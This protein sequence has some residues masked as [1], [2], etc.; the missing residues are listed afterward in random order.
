MNSV[1]SLKCPK[2]WWDAVDRLPVKD[3]I[4]LIA[5]DLDIEI[6][7]GIVPFDRWHRFHCFRNAMSH[8]RRAASGEQILEFDADEMPRPIHR[9]VKVSWEVE[10]TSPELEKKLSSAERHDQGAVFQDTILKSTDGTW[11]R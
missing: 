5:K 8:P 10:C 11:R 2:H 1:G 6:D 4:Q 9:I 3:K 7:F